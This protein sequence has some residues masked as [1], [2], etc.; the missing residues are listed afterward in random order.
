MESTKASLAAMPEG[1]AK[2][3]A[4]SKFKMLCTRLNG[5]MRAAAAPEHEPG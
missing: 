3:D 2:Q 1:K 5:T 4:M